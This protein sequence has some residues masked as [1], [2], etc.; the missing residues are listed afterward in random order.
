MDG[1]EDVMVKFLVK[2][3]HSQLMDCSVFV[4]RRANST[5]AHLLP[6]ETRQV[7][8]F[9]CTF[10]NCLEGQIPRCFVALPLIYLLNMKSVLDNL[11]IL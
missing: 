7:G 2:L 4:E 3:R 9:A 11:D 5:P 8:M 6:R 1:R 10:V